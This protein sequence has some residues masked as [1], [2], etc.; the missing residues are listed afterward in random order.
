MVRLLP[1]VSSI[2]FLKKS[3]C[4]DTG[5]ARRKKDSTEPESVP[6]ANSDTIRVEER[7]DQK[8]QVQLFCLTFIESRVP[9]VSP[10]LFR[11]LLSKLIS[12]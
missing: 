10:D 11:L 12:I 6:C 8:C 3:L 9:R 7:A 4:Q 2:T 5:H 1:G